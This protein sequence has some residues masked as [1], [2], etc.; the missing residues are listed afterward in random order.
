MY[1]LPAALE[2]LIEE[3]QKLPGIGPRT[4]YRLAFF[5]LKMDTEDA[6]SLS[7]A[8]SELKEKVKYCRRCFNLSDSDTC[9]I[10]ENLNRNQRIICVV[11]QPQD[12]FS[13]EK[14]GEYNGVYHVL[15]GAISPADGVGPDQL[16]INELI[17]RIENEEV[18]EVI[19]ATNPNVNGEI[20]AAYLVRLLSGKVP[21]ITQ[22]ATGVPFGGD[23]DFADEITIARAIQSRREVRNE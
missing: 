12:V 22:L 20:T 21:K 15:G 16:H 6:R 4:A 23:L 19:V 3:L 14:T 18:E 1:A 7:T 2:K 11:E 5:I 13:I 10:C 9:K 8:I 17:S